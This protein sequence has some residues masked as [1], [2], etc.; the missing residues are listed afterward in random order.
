[1]FPKD[2]VLL[3]LR[4]IFENN[5]KKFANCEMGAVNGFASGVV[6]TTAVQSEEIWTGVTYALASMMIHE[7]Q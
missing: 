1:M 2:K 7:V 4:T 6:D 5:V 3:S